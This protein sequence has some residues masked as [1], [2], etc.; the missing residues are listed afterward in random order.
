LL[1]NNRLNAKNI[2]EIGIGTN[3]LMKSI[4]GDRYEVGA[5]IK[6]WRDFFP[7]AGIFGLDIEKDVLFEEDRIKCF[8]SDQSKSSVLVETINEIRKY[9]NDENLL[10]D[11]ILDDGS[12]ILEHQ[13]LTYKTLFNY[14]NINGIYIIEDIQRT[15]INSI[16]KAIGTEGK[17]IEIHQGLPTLNG[18]VFITIKK[19]K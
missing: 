7:N 14:L 15:N 11:M 6:A 1:N 18:D 16:V 2:I 19:E 4:V 10:F 12:H 8:Y 3:Q 17:V 5:S 13:I 9:K